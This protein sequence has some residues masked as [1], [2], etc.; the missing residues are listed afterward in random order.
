ML[1]SRRRTRGVWAAVAVGAAAV[2]AAIVVP[3]SIGGSKRTPKTR[4][5]HA[6]AVRPVRVLPT[7]APGTSLVAESAVPVLPVYASRRGVP[8]LALR[9]QNE[10]GSPLVLLVKRYARK[11]LR[12]YLPVRPNGALGWVH[13]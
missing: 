7:L 3:L 8:V 9:R 4:A 12:V 1:P 10:S 5:A 13:T 11:W 6:V 2:T